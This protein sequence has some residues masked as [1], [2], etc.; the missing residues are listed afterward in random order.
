MACPVA[1]RRCYRSPGATA[2]ELFK[3][4]RSAR[5]WDAFFVVIVPFA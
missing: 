5:P 1:K 3:L 2:A 4:P